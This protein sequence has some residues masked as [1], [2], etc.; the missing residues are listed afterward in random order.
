MGWQAMAD[1]GR[2]GLDM[3]GQG[4][5]WQG[6][7]DVRVLSCRLWRYPGAGEWK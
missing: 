7:V 4:W 5:I 3:A 6:R 1:F 2:A